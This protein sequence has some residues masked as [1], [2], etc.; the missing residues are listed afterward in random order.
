MPKRDYL[1]SLNDL[2]VL[3]EVGAHGPANGKYTA[4]DEGDGADL[5]FLV[6]NDLADP[7]EM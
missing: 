6:G 5:A 4:V 2:E 1:G 3:L 7:Y